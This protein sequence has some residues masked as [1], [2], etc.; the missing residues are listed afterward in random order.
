MIRSQLYLKS[1]FITF[2]AYISFV[3]LLLLAQLIL[4]WLK[5]NM[6]IAIHHTITL[7][8][9]NLT[10]FN[11][12]KILWCACKFSHITITQQSC[13]C[14]KVRKYIEYKVLSLKCKQISFIHACHPRCKNQMLPFPP[15][16]F[17]VELSHHALTPTYLFCLGWK[18]PHSRIVYKILHNLLN[19]A[20]N[21]Q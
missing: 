16:A 4:P 12:S 8:L 13:H 5:L 6:I 10:A 9:I 18:H 7:Q 14:D 11:Q 3:T 21:S 2:T 17:H 19:H 20:K 1:C 15:Y